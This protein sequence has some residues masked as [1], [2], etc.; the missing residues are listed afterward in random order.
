[1]IHIQ[2][3]ILKSI[4][5]ILL[6]NFLGASTFAQSTQSV[7]IIFN[8]INNNTKNYKVILDANSFF[9]NINYNNSD[10]DQNIVS[11]DNLKA[12]KH[13]IKIYRLGNNNAK[14][15]NSSK[16]TFMYSKTFDLR[17][18][19]DMDISI[20]ASG[21]VQL[22][23]SPTS[24]VVESDD[25]T[26]MANSDFNQLLQSVRGKFS[27]AL[28]GET[29]NDAFNNPKN[30]FTTSQ[31]KQLLTLIT[32][33][34]DRVDLAKL[35]YRS[36]T[37][38][39]NFTRI[40][41]LFKSKASRD[42]L[43][44]F[45][46]SKGWNIANDQSLTKTPMP[47]N[48]FNSLL[49]SVRGK[50]SQALKGETESDAFTNSNNYFSTSQIRQLLTLITSESDRV[51]LAKLSYRSV[52]D[53]ANFTQLYE[54]FKTKVSR[55]ELN[56]FLNS[57]GWNIATSQNLTKTP[58]AEN[59]FNSLLQS[60]KGKWSQALKGETENDAFNNSNN[61]FSTSQIRQ[62]L[63]LITSENDRLDLA[64]LS[65]RSVTDSSNFTQLYDLFKTQE[66]KDELNNFLRTKGWNTVNNQS[67]KTP[68]GDAD[69][70]QLLNNVRGYLI[71][72]LKVGYETDLFN[73]PNYYFST[74]QIRQLLLLINAENNRLEL[75]KLSYRIVTDPANFPQLNNLFTL[76]SSRDELANYVKNH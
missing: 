69:F 67:S 52:T 75:A 63:T 27:Q 12:K 23:E 40:Y 68:M 66:S 28:K 36:V 46:R 18:G 42:E 58:M 47:D 3:K 24:G 9:S 43:N 51:D 74:S 55:D 2:A 13:T 4:L 14:Y 59:K 6:C 19:Y 50:F 32:S 45:L 21:R 35:S 65:Y 57:K 30:Y 26:P 53:S 8:G 10:N 7:N 5:I 54:L 70:N 49:Q 72:F 31:I 62:L 38:S 41:D 25:K 44:D 64:K 17:E 61:Y 76:Q 11:I 60:V 48:K 33:E 73:N 37:D 56:D 71:Q 39:A 15:N 1:M 34:S 29:E 20:N 22:S 16:K